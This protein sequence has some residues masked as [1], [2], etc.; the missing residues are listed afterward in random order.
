MSF[1]LQEIRPLYNFKSNFLD[2]NGLKYHYLDEGQGD[3]LVMVHGNPAWSFMYRDLVRALRTS[4]R[5][6]VP[7]HIGCGLSDKPDDSVYEYRLEQ[8][9]NDLEAL[10]DQLGLDRDITLILHDWGGLIGLSYATRH[11]SRVARLVILNTAAFFLPS[12]KSLHW[13]LRWCRDS[14]LAAFLIRRLNLFARVASHVGCRSHPMPPAVRRA[15]TGPYDSWANRIATLRFVQDIPLNP[16]DRSYQ[17][18]LKTQ[19]KLHLLQDK[20]W[21]ICWGNRDFIF[22][23]DFLR[24]WRRRFPGAEVRQF[25]EAGHYVL[26]DE[27]EE[28]ISR[29]R[30]FL[31]SHPLEKG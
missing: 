28:V 31:I 4:W 29:I 23:A 21:L 20:P 18:L 10:L 26:E 8:R 13:S 24:E 19:E 1:S 12:G 11:P 30:D 25:P 2:R 17:T 15:Y 27:S 22:D 3:V 14:R 9:V 16:S 5:T 6:L 7:D